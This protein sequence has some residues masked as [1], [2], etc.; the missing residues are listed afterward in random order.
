MHPLGLCNNNDE[1]DLY[2]YGWVGVVKLEQPELDPK[3][4]LTVLGKISQVSTQPL[5]FPPAVAA[6]PSTAGRRCWEPP[7]R[8][9]ELRETQ[10]W[11]SP[12]TLGALTPRPSPA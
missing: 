1:E 11:V 4:C 8:E 3:P 9:T 2:E 10:G 7:S 12:A 5:L 6:W